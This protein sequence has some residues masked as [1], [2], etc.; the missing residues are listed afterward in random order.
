MSNNPKILLKPHHFL[1][2]IKLYGLGL[3]LFV[4]DSRYGHNF[5]KVGNSILK[6][7]QSIIIL[8]TKADDICKPCKFLKKSKCADKMR[9]FVYSSKEEWN[10]IVDKK[11][12]KRL[13]LNEENGLT[14]L[15]FCKLA[16]QKL[17]SKI[18]SE[19]WRE[20]PKKE[21]KR[22]IKYLLRGLDRYIE[23]FS[24]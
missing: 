22:R 2:T 23:K 11:I 21:T 20:R 17:N 14:A 13:N 12:L 24:V 18:I 6:N 7:P 10:Q 9:S 3:N 19:I 15:E 1:D 16:N 4:P 8:T 5:Y